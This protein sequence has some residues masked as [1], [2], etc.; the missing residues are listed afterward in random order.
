MSKKYNILLVMSD[1]HNKSISGCYGDPIV[2]T[3][4]FDD[5]ASRGVLF[6]N[7][8]CPFPLCAPAR[9][10]FMTGKIPS[11]IGMYS[12][13]SVLSSDEP[14][15]AHSLAQ[16]GYETI[17][18]GRMHFNG[19][20]QRHGFNQRIFP[21][22]STSA[23]GTLT[24]TNGF[25][26]VS[27]EKSGPGKNHYLHYDEKCMSE[28]ISWL[29]KRTQSEDDKPFCMLVGLVGPHC[30]FV[31][32]QELFDKYFDK[33][34][35]PKYSEKDLS[36]MSTYNRRFRE[37]SHID[38]ASALEIKRT[39]AAYYGMI[40]FDDELVGRLLSTLDD[41]KLRDDTIVI[42][43]S[44]HGEMAGEH[45]MWWKM[46]FYEGS[47]GVPMIIS[48]P[49]ISRSGEREKTPVSIVD[50]APTLVE[51][52]NAPAISDIDGHSLIP[53]LN[54]TEYNYNRSVFSEIFVDS[55]SWQKWG[56]SGGPAR[57]LRKGS[58]KC[59]YYHNEEPELFNLDE[60]PQEMNNLAQDPKC[61]TIL[62]KM[63][64]DIL[65]NWNPDELQED[66]NVN[67]QKS[68]RICK[69]VSDNEYWKG[70]EGYGHVNQI[71]K[72]K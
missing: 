64:S 42:Y 18:C 34:K 46:S 39:R 56:P 33:I 32:P 2:S 72:E 50:L 9:M 38:N 5:L 30:P 29:N 31:C 16:N 22:V 47:A 4:N 23:E 49:G 59:I 6:E 10:S 36:R 15:F 58:W 53:Y 68:A 17:L 11:R 55:K 26:R 40:E 13:S 69:N 1:Q 3:P 45:G 28:A 62:A 67:A 51:M 20:D 57:M 8:Y 43:V 27:L 24:G 60:D 19:P 37:R 12:N 70:P 71:N 7:A 54:G 25:S 35:I 41:T 21:E 61:K 44:D 14:T 63:L 52:G 65:S 48:G 66:M